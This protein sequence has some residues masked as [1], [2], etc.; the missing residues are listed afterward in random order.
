MSDELKN[1]E[2][3]SSCHISDRYVE[4]FTKIRHRIRST[5]F[6]IRFW[7]HV[8]FCVYGSIGY[9]SYR[10]NNNDES[11][12][13]A[14]SGCRSCETL[15]SWIDVWETPIR[16]PIQKRVSFF[17]ATT[18]TQQYY[19]NASESLKYKFVMSAFRIAYDK[20]VEKVVPIS[21]MWV[22][23]FW[24]EAVAHLNMCVMRCESEI[25]SSN[26]VTVK[27]RI[28]RNWILLWRNSENKLWRH[29]VR[30]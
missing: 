15:V 20:R 7:S 13:F 19:D 3:F 4:C 6:I 21:H 25:G 9:L 12:L 16:V 11:S 17:F 2:I 24:L 29:V 1:W 14:N 26:R 5:H 10:K 22:T 18:H 8:R 28:V 23:G 27:N 30:D